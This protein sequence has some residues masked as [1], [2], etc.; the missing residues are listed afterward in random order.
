MTSRITPSRGAW[1]TFSDSMMIRSPRCGHPYLHARRRPALG[2]HRR[3]AH[4]R[5]CRRRQA[6]GAEVTNDAGGRH[7]RGRWGIQWGASALGRPRPRSVR[8]QRPA[9]PRARSSR[10]A[11][12]GAVAPRRSTVPR[13]RIARSSAGRSPPAASRSVL[14]PPAVTSVASYDAVILGSGV[15]VGHWM[16]AAGTSSSA[17]RRLVRRP[18]WLF[19]SGRSA[20]PR[21][22]ENAVDI[23]A[24][25]TDMAPADTAS[26]PARRQVPT[27]PGEKVILKAVRASEGDYRPWDEIRA[28]AGE[29]ATALKGTPA[30]P[31]A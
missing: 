24:I 13:P 31:P 1:P 17:R 14:P 22:C 5:A 23:E 6:T 4:P 18:V 2:E 26:S 28:W 7:L 25:M 30:P 10:D 15:Y 29:I 20:T 27:R 9:A 3:D 12:E 19:S 16:D 8:G 11:H 21:A